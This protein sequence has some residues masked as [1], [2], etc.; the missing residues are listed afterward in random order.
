MQRQISRIDFDYVQKELQKLNL[1]EFEQTHRS[2]AMKLLSVKKQEPL[3][4]QEAEMLE[5]YLYP[6][7]FNADKLTRLEHRSD[8]QTVYGSIYSVDES[9]HTGSA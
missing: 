3:T 9:D 8:P 5:R 2:L 7:D 6:E 4:K 1:A